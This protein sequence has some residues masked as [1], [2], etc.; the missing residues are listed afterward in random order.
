MDVECNCECVCELWRSLRGHR[1]CAA[2]QCPHLYSRTK[3]KGSSVACCGVVWRGGTGGMLR[4]WVS[5]CVR[6]QVVGRRRSDTRTDGGDTYLDFAKS[7]LVLTVPPIV[8]SAS[9]SRRRPI[10]ET[11]AAAGVPVGV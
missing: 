10:D 1:M 11:A 6:G 3:R 9:S 2:V 5:E 7:G 8:A 4:E